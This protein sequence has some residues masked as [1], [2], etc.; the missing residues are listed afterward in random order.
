VNRRL[1]VITAL[2]AFVAVV[3]ISSAITAL[4]LFLRHPFDD[5]AEIVFNNQSNREI[6]SID[7]DQGNTHIR[8]I[9]IHPSERRLRRFYADVPELDTKC[10]I[11]IHY[12][13]T[14]VFNLKL[15]ISNGDKDEV[16]ISEK[17]AFTIQRQGTTL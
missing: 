2:I 14:D 7:I 8:E 16:M 9:N 4:V 1:K 12:S 5:F 11:S 10:N 3:A 6:Q 13:K 17:D 15:I